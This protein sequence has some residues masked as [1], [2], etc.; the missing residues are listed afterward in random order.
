MPGEG[1]RKRKEKRGIEE[2]KG[3]G[4]RGGEGLYTCNDL[5]FDLGNSTRRAAFPPCY[6]SHLSHCIAPLFAVAR[7][8]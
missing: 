4:K 3:E 1:E 7:Q 8:P 2:K 5:P 6:F